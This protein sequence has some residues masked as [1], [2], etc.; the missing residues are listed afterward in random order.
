MIRERIQEAVARAG[1]IAPLTMEGPYVMEVVCENP[2]PAQLRPGAERVDAFTIRYRGD[3]F[4]GVF[5]RH[6]YGDPDQPWPA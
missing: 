2:W 1:K 6:I 5:H 3:R 4:W